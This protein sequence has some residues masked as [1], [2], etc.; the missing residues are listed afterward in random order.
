[1]AYTEEID[2]DWVVKYGKRKEKEM[3][4]DKILDLTLYMK[5]SVLKRA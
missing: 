5:R 2:I 1:L 3:F 4:H